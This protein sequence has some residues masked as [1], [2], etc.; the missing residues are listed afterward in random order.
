VKS[1]SFRPFSKSPVSQ[2]T[3]ATRFFL[4]FVG[5]RDGDVGFGLVVDDGG[6]FGHGFV[7]GEDG[8]ELFVDDL[9]LGEGGEGLL[10]GFGGDG[11]DAVADVADLGVEHEGV[12]GGG[13]RE[14]LA[15]G[16]VG[17]ARHVAMPEDGLDAGHLFGGGDVDG[18]QAGMGVGAPEHL[19]DEGVAGGEVGDVGGLAEGELLGID[20]GDGVV[21]LLEVGGGVGGH[22]ELLMSVSRIQDSEFRIRTCRIGKHGTWG[23]F[24]AAASWRS[25]TFL[26]AD[27]IF[28]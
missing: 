21:D 5:D 16:D 19:D 15:G 2:A 1:A 26:R 27:Q 6:A 20:L 3:R 25:R 18:G 10:L 4:G 28:S 12:V 13:F 11:G 17:D 22:G 7:D 9:D 23:Y 24:L 14:T 8:G